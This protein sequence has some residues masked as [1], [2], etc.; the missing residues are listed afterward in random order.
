[1]ALQDGRNQKRRHADAQ[2]REEIG[3]GPEWV[4]AVNEVGL[5]SKQEVGPFVSP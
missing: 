2:Q 3:G 1:M 5:H 4:E